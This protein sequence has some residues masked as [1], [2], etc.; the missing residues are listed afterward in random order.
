MDGPGT[1]TWEEFLEN[2]E[3]FIQMSNRISDGWEL[4]GNKVNETIS[5]FRVFTMVTIAFEKILNDA[6]ENFK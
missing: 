4:K 3:N 1:I 6:I 2:T 5:L